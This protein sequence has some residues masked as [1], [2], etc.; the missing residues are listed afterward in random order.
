M[1][2]CG[3]IL[4]ESHGVPV[5]SADFGGPQLITAPL[6]TNKACCAIPIFHLILNSRYL[7]ATVD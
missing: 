7:V 2:Y 5:F 4:P 1:K 6:N 3:Y